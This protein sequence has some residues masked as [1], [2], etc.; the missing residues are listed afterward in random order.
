LTVYPEP[1]I[2]V[3]PPSP[4]KVA[5]QF[6]TASEAGRNRTTLDDPMT[7]GHA[8]RGWAVAGPNTD[9]IT[10]WRERLHELGDAARTAACGITSAMDDYIGADE[11]AGARLNRDARWLEDA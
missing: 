2:T 6:H 7:A 1:G 10:A 4:T 9:C 5:R 3:E 11:S 8:H